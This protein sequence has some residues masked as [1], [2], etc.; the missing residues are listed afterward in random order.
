MSYMQSESWWEARIKHGAYLG[1]IESPEHYIWR[2]MRSRCLRVSDPSF[3]YYGGRGIKVCE[4]WATFENFLDDMGER[5]SSDHSLDRVDVNGDYCPENCRWATRSEQQ[6]NKST[7]RKFAGRGGFIG[8]LVECAQLLGISKELAHWR[9][10]NW[11]TFCKGEE[12]HELPK[13]L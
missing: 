1:G 11:G 2:S 5:P 7:T 6:K 12:W 13:A 4:R 8:T 10:K 3:S 9:F